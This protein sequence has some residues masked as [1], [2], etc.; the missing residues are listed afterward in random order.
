MSRTFT[1]GFVLAGLVAYALGQAPTAA[2]PI[3]MAKVPSWK[4]IDRLISEQKYSAAL[5]GAQARL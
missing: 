3:S 4:E 5:D 1:L 2:K